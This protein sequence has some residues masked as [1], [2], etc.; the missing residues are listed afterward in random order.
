MTVK[1]GETIK[2]NCEIIREIDDRKVLNLLSKQ[3]VEALGPSEGSGFDLRNNKRYL[4]FEK[5]VI[6]YCL[7]EPNVT[8]E[9]D[10]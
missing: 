2:I 8:I 9:F 7:N 1:P 4:E 10:S 5:G 6:M 3:L